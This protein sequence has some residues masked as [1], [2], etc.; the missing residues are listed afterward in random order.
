MSQRHPPSEE[1]FAYRDGELDHD[2]RG[3]VEAHVLSCT[4]CQAR[5]DALSDAEAVLREQTADP[6]ADYY[7]RLT[8]AVLSRVANEP[9]ERLAPPLAAVPPP[10]RAGRRRNFEDAPRGRA[11]G[12]PWP[13]IVS[14]VSAAAAVVVVAVLLFQRQDAWRDSNVGPVAVAPESAAP[15]SDQE[16]ERGSETVGGARAQGEVA[17]SRDAD[18]AADA[19]TNGSAAPPPPREVDPLAKQEAAAPSA[20]DPTQ[21]LG[22]TDREAARGR[23]N[24]EEI[25]TESAA[26]AL[27]EIADRRLAAEKKADDVAARFTAPQAI[28]LK[29]AADAPAKDEAKNVVPPPGPTYAQIVARY[30]LPP[31]FDPLRVRPEALVRAEGELRTLYQTGGAG[32]DS[33]RTRIY[34]AEAARARAGD[35]LDVETYDA[36]VQH[37]RR[38]I[39]LAPDP[40]TARV[41]RQR[42]EDFVSR[43][44]PRR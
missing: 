37:Y 26:E 12:L 1:L 33:A 17:R 10:P 18:A 27:P 28:R 22:R 40:A 5:V 20:A 2:R 34:L 38:A 21:E 30:S 32:G 16:K 19:A 29:S 14:T 9:T 31:L 3:L 8:D 41:A 39:Q 11:P 7:G 24:V 23:A 4:T 36:I 43:S 6:G 25:R 44:A 13:A 35:D 15:G 42:L